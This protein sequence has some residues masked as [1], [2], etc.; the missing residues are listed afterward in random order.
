M[1]NYKGSFKSNMCRQCITKQATTLVYLFTPKPKLLCDAC[2]SVYHSSFRKE[3]FIQPSWR[4]IFNTK[5]TISPFLP[6]APEY[7]SP[8]DIQVVRR[9]NFLVVLT[10][11]DWSEDV[12]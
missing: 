7:L 9:L 10:I 4:P 2:A 8:N 5:L 1:P 6:K 12:V 3:P 11:M